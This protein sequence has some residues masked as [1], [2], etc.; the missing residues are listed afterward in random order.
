M[1]LLDRL[2]RVSPNVAYAVL[3]IGGGVLAFAIVRRLRASSAAVDPEVSSLIR[4]AQSEAIIATLD[5]TIRPMARKLLQRAAS[6]G[7]NLVVTQGRRTM[8]EQ[9][10]LYAQGR[11]APG[12][13]VTNSPPGSSWHN[14][15]LA[16]DVAVIA[17]DGSITWPNDN[18]LWQQIGS[19][20][21]NLGLTWGGSFVSFVD[22]P[23]FEYHPGLTLADARSGKRPA[24]SAVV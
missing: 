9:A 17:P 24:S 19:I 20:G 15:A 7:I 18:A 23:H 12:A 8:E 11:T 2:P 3:G 13:I 10:A 16:F 6:T 21:S 14:F 1:S 4:G 22:R 5:P